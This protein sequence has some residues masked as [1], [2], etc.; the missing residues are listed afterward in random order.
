MAKATPAGIKAGMKWA[1]ELKEIPAEERPPLD[2]HQAQK[3]LGLFKAV[4]DDLS[5]DDASDIETIISILFDYILQ[6]WVHRE[7][8]FLVFKG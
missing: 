6:V 2:H 7:H 1:H 4:S 3:F 5:P 8:F